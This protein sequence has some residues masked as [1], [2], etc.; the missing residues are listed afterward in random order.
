MNAHPSSG[1][2]LSA[3]IAIVTLAVVA[4]AFIGITQVM[5]FRAQPGA[6]PGGSGGGSDRYVAPSGAFA[7]QKPSG[8]V[9]VY[10]TE[11]DAG[12]VDVSLVHMRAQLSLNSYRLDRPDGGG[13]YD[14]HLLKPGA[15]LPYEKPTTPLE[16]LFQGGGRIQAGLWENYS[17]EPAT[18]IQTKLGEGLMTR[19]RAQPGGTGQATVG[20]R[21]TLVGDRKTDVR[22]QGSEADWPDVGPKVESLVRSLEPAGG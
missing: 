6:V 12:R 15:H 16:K 10:A 7:F 17:E 2:P 22:S 4:L 19:Y 5:G 14:N 3:R 21:A 1:V 8:W 18:K 11:G 9:V 13:L 20:V